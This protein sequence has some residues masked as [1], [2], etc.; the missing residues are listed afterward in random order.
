MILLVLTLDV[1]VVE[2]I[3]ILLLLDIILNR[4]G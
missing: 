1:V 4:W 3:A 2:V